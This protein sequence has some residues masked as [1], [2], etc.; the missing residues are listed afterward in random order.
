MSASTNAPCTV[1]ALQRVRPDCEERFL[2][3]Q[4]KIS[5]AMRG[6]PGF[7]GRE[8]IRPVPG[9]QD[10]WVSVFRFA[11]T[12]ALRQWMESGERRTMLQESEEFAESPGRLQVLAGD[13][14]GQ[15]VV[16]VVFSHRVKDGCT[17]AFETWRRD[18]LAA[19]G[20]WPGFLGADVFE[21]KKGV[22]DDAVL[23]ARFESA[24]SF[25]GWMASPQRARLL[26]RLEPLIEGYTA[27]PLGSGLGGWFAFDDATA[28]PSE[29]PAWKQILMVTLG[30]YPTVM[31][32]TVFVDPWMLWLSFP[33]RMIISNLLCVSLLTWPVMPWLNRRFGRWLAPRAVHG[34]RAD[35][36]GALVVA[37]LLALWVAFFVALWDRLS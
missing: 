30:L 20:R 22:Q 14:T 35:A 31:L 5:T 34:W 12:G 19:M 9:L 37:V 4:E 3:W 6:Y 7:L 11:S 24:A 15:P 18:V 25:E 33:S 8:L 28:A 32:L 36:L 13:E 29:P 26:E 1:L 27:Q 2:S 21:A 16:T 10:E 17:P 23:M